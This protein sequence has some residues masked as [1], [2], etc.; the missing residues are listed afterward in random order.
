MCATVGDSGSADEPLQLLLHKYMAGEAQAE[1]QRQSFNATYE[2]WVPM[3]DLHDCSL[4]AG[5]QRLK[6]LSKMVQKY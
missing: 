2:V 1:S 5:L 3:I 4:S 6:A